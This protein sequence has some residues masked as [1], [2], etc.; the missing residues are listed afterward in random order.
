MSDV[1][2]RHPTTVLAEKL[3]VMPCLAS[4]LLIQSWLLVSPHCNWQTASREVGGRLG[5]LAWFPDAGLTKIRLNIKNAN[6]LF[7]A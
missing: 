1:D 3:V 2:T 4:S 5:W 6:K 7:I